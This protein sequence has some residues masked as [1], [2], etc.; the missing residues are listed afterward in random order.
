[1]TGVQ[2]C[3]LPIFHNLKNLKNI[4]IKN[5]IKLAVSSTPDK[6]GRPML[7]IIDHS[8]G[9]LLVRIRLY[10]SASKASHYIEIG[11]LLKQLSQ[12]SNLSN[13]PT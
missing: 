6:D 1:M 8:S 12:L 7:N 5:N 11:N 2:T 4:L 10:L 3:A 13:I 9:N